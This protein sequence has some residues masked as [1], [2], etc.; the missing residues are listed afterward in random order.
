MFTKTET[1]E[2][3]RLAAK[4]VRAERGIPTNYRVEVGLRTV[5]KYATETPTSIREAFA[6]GDDLAEYL[7]LR[8][9][10]GEDEVRTP[11]YFAHLYFSQPGAY[12]ELTDIEVVWLGT[13]DED[14]VVYLPLGS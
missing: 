3:L 13:A 8:S 10:A 7:D 6:E 9:A 11:G 4:I 5:S 1:L 12:G 2:R 14:Y